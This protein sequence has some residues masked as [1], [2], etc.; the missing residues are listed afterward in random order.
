MR[1]DCWRF[2][3]QQVRPACIMNAPTIYP[4]IDC[5]ESV[6]RHEE[7]VSALAVSPDGRYLATAATYGTVM[8]WSDTVSGK[9]SLAELESPDTDVPITSLHFSPDSEFLA[10]TQ[11]SH[12]LIWRASDLRMVAISAGRFRQ[13]SCV[14]RSDTCSDKISILSLG[15]SE[16]YRYLT[17]STISTTIAPVQTTW[18]P[19]VDG[20]IPT[21]LFYP[22]TIVLG[23]YPSR[24]TSSAAVVQSS[25]GESIWSTWTCRGKRTF[26]IWRHGADAPSPNHYSLHDD[27]QRAPLRVYHRVRRVFR[28]PDSRSS[29]RTF[30]RSSAMTRSHLRC[31]PMA[32]PSSKA[33]APN[34]VSYLSAPSSLTSPLHH[35]PIYDTL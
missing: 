4:Y 14:W 1:V 5:E 30:C 16:K 18:D 21:P 31:V 3:S 2:R 22:T 28:P 24:S 13:L 35:L 10:A 25:S 6:Q 15:V 12:V 17:I 32:N 34:P 23:L 11:G 9:S 33:G 27:E 8:L 19:S 29:S 7:A 20:N 26:N